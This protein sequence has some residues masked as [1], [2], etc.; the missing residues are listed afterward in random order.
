MLCHQITVDQKSTSEFAS[1]VQNP[2]PFVHYDHS[3]LRSLAP[4]R[5]TK[6]S[7]LQPVHPTAIRARDLADLL[8]PFEI[9][10]ISTSLISLFLP[11]VFSIV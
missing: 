3:F 7:L 6:S 2:N 8:L 10:S 1:Q 4:D 9:L 5:M 11:S